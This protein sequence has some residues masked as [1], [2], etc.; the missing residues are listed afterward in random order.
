MLLLSFSTYP[1]VGKCFP[2][3]VLE[4]VRKHEQTQECY[5]AQGEK[6]PLLERLPPKGSCESS[7]LVVISQNFQLILT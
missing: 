2:A 6:K 5:L 3:Y 1:Q 7:V 4:D